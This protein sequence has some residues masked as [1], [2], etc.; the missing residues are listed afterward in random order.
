VD[1]SEPTME[2]RHRYYIERAVRA[3][4]VCDPLQAADYTHSR[5]N[6][7]K[8]ALQSLIAEGVLLPINVELV[9]GKLHEY[10]IHRDD[11]TTLRQAA[12]GALI[13]SLTTFL[14]PF[15]SLFWGRNR[16]EELFGFDQRIEC[17][18]PEPKRIWGYFSLPI[19]HNDRLV[20]RFD[21]K[22]ER[23]TGHLRIKALHLEPEV[24]PSDELAAAIAQTMQGFM[25]FHKATEVTIER[26]T[27]IGFDQTVSKYL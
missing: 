1:T 10:V 15:D 26:S 9:D 24:S 4:G 18:T 25:A 17:Y 27:P 8:S 14:S 2:E 22:L 21:P 5:R 19:L 12:D 16:D 11:V 6:A 7:T 23:K 13:P 3:H 20:G